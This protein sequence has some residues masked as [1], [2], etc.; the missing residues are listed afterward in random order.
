M[1]RRS[2]L[3]LLVVSVALGVVLAFGGQ[4]D[5]KPVGAGRSRET[6]GRGAEVGEPAPSPEPATPGLSPASPSAGPTP[7]AD[8]TPSASG[9]PETIVVDVET[10]ERSE[11]P[12]PGAEV[13]AIAH[14]PSLADGMDETVR[15]RGETD[16]DGVARLVVPT[17]GAYRVFASAEGRHPRRTRVQVFPGEEARVG[18]RLPEGPGVD[19]RVVDPDGRPILGA[20]VR[21]S[22]THLERA[23]KAASPVKDPAGILWTGDGGRFRVPGVARDW[24][25]VIRA[26][27]PGFHHATAEVFDPSVPDLVVRLEPAGRI[28]GTVR[29]RAGKPVAGARVHVEP[30][31][32]GDDSSEESDA[33]PAVES[34]DEYDVTTRSDGTFV[35]DG[36]ALGTS[37]C[38]RARAN[39]YAPSEDVGPVVS[40]LAVA[41]ARADVVLRRPA[42]IVVHVSGEEGRAPEEAWV[43][44]KGFR[45][46]V[47]GGGTCRIEGLSPGS[48]EVEVSS[49]LYRKAS[50]VVRVEEGQIREIAVELDPAARIEGVVTG[51]EGLWLEGVAVWV[52]S[53]DGRFATYVWP[54]AQGRFRVGGLD[55]GEY[56]VSGVQARKA[57]AVPLRVQA[58]AR[59]VRVIFEQHGSVRFRLLGPDGS[60]YTQPF[61]G[62]VTHGHGGIRA[63]L[64]T[65]FEG[66]GSGD[67]VTILR[68]VVPGPVTVEVE[69]EGFPRLSFKGALREGGTAD[70][71]DQTLPAGVPV[72]GVVRDSTG[73]SVSGAEVEVGEIE[74]RTGADGRFL[75]HGVPGEARLLVR[76]DGFA[77]VKRTIRVAL[78]AP[79]LE[80]GLV[81]L[82]RLRGPLK[83]SRGAR[84][85]GRALLAIPVDAPEAE[86]QGGRIAESRIDGRVEF[87]LLPGTWRVSERVAPGDDTPP[88][89]PIG[90]W[91]LAEGEEREVE[92]VLPER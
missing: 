78:G 65:R 34:D 72:T 85:T 3:A 27:A 5:V 87:D 11:R 13:L 15:V 70:L 31:G 41:D 30:F 89:R 8:A 75:V 88:S 49:P 86:D 14:A 77:R 71:G 82:A 56:V 4:R 39:G 54:D 12:V 42:T 50:E 62:T 69:A 80:I 76:A 19:G 20:T 18:I 40:N 81:R 10:E 61:Q 9:R 92:F 58:P 57:L 24:G 53:L 23:R 52:Q 67:G 59:D 51:P 22:V 26:E 28:R 29:N 84:L 36:T 38:I 44:S 32:G 25:L 73:G 90:V 48:F 74:V 6:P 1:A 33:K 83:D 66:D 16:E 35:V 46:R 63:D 45:E 7:D 21:Y 64:E 60:P 47:D 17:P 2:A 91:T 79:S 68:D 55:A 37:Y 43:S